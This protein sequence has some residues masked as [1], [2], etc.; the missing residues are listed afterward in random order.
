MAANDN[1]SSCANDNDPQTAVRLAHI[2][3]LLMQVL[4]E[5]RARRSRAAKR[6]RTV[7]ERAYDRAV[8]SPIQP[9]E[10]QRA[11]ARRAIARVRRRG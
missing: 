1:G 7:A 6:T 2:E 9:T 4:R 5:L 11:A 3:S 10:L 8:A